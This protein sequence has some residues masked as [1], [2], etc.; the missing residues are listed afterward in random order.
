MLEQTLAKMKD[1][2]EAANRMWEEENEKKMIK[3][4][5][6]IVNPVGSDAIWIF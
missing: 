6:D 4:F 3:H 5:E 1:K 2:I